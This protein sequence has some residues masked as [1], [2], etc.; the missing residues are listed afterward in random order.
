MVHSIES[1]SCANLNNMT[2]STNFFV[3][4]FWNIPVL[5][6]KRYCYLVQILKH[7]KLKNTNLKFPFTTTLSA[8]QLQLTCR[9]PTDQQ[10]LS[11]RSAW[12]SPQPS[13]KSGTSFLIRF[14]TSKDEYEQH[15]MRGDNWHHTF[16]SISVLLS[17][18][19][20]LDL[21]LPILKWWTGVTATRFSDNSVLHHR[22]V[23]VSHRSTTQ[24]R[25]RK[26]GGRNNVPFL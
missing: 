5:K 16:V 21:Q 1:A 9:I 11:V 13:W 20:S 8:K 3:L 12:P 23:S 14:F 4:C 24:T 25:T 7:K 6:K 2:V 10:P 18:L 22:R 19:L 17:T 15:I 26:W